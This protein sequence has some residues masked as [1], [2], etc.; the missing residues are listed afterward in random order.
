MTLHIFPPF[1]A[2][3]PSNPSTVAAGLSGQIY[4]STDLSFTTPLT[5]TSLNAQPLTELVSND[6]GLVSGFR[7]DCDGTAVWKS[8]TYVVPLMAPQAL[9]QEVQNAAAAAAAAASGGVPPGGSVG[10]VL[11]KAS[12]ASYDTQWFTLV[13]VIGPTDAWPTG[14]PDGTVVVRSSV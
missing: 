8:G 4:A 13:V 7:A 6:I 11:R 3:D 2:V 10:Q 14:L 12:G 5:I 9:L 1:I